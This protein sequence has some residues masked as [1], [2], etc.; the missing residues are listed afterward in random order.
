MDEKF[1]VAGP[2]N[3]TQALKRLQLDPLLKINIKI[4]EQQLIIPIWV[5]GH[6][7]AVNM[8][9][10][11][12]FEE[13]CFHIETRDYPG[14]SRD[15]ILD[16]LSHLFHW[17]IPLEKVADF[18][19]DKDL[20]PLFEEYRG[21]PFVCDFQMYGCLMKVII[22]QQLNM[23]FAF[24]LSERFVKTF[25][26]QQDDAWFYPTPEEVSE[27]EVSQLRE[28][29]FS[30]RKAEYVIDTS[31]MIAEGKLDLH[32]L[33]QQADDEVIRTLVKIR[34]IGPWTAENFL[35]FGLGRMDLF[36]I[37]DI[38]IQNGMKKFFD[39]EAKPTHETMLEKSA[40]WKP[41]RTYASLYLWESI[42]T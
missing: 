13:P 2:Y 14:V 1:K 28:L 35:M 5:K 17:N 4:K 25:G 16:Q 31:R 32:E 41:Y 24:T 6:P 7:I 42:E 23:T 10:I 39:W 8:K 21:T 34:G 11:G 38:G 27:L 15:E 18:F 33:A 26:F 37:Q 36:P 30:Q 22:H 19:Q 12:T 9:Q 40:E 20:G 29:Q 3:F